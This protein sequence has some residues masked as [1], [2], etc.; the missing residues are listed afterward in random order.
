VSKYPALGSSHPVG[1]V[2][3]GLQQVNELEGLGVTKYS[4]ANN[5]KIKYKKRLM[6]GS[7]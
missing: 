5:K 6:N 1:S 3:G 7:C 4:V 2:F